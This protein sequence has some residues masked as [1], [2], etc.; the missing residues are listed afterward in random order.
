MWQI[1]D[2]AGRPDWRVLDTRLDCNLYAVVQT[3]AGA[4]AVGGRGTVAA[5]YGDGW[6]VV[7]DDGPAT[8]QNQLRAVDVTDDGERI[9]LVGSGGSMACY[10]VAER[11]KFDFGYPEALT[12]TWEAITV[13]GP[14]GSEKA[15]AASGSGEILP[16]AVDGVDPDWGH[17]DRVAGAEATIAVLGSTPEGVGF[18][19]DTAGSA[20][21]TTPDEGWTS[22]GV[23]DADATFSAIHAGANEQVYVAAAGGDIYRYG[24]TYHSWTPIEVGADVEIRT[25][26][27]YN[28]GDGRRQMAVLSEDGAIYV[29]AAADRWKERPAPT[30][31]RL[32]SLSLGDPDVIVG[33]SGTVVERPR[34][35]A[36]A[37]DRT[38]V[39]QSRRVTGYETRSDD[40]VDTE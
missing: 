26:D 4:Y 3:A 20:F 10:D 34:A 18:A 5:N 12:S 14:R 6:E 27:V 39:P 9:W 2:A 33:K 13:S 16:F 25:I 8:R 23:L 19:V 11:R 31:T 24:D 15:L 21:K 40:R 1:G 7:F 22:I 17:L 28:S 29:R 30:D 37:A 38:A 36:V 35:A 32:Y